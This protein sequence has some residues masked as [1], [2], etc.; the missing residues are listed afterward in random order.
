[1]KKDYSLQMMQVQKRFS[2]SSNNQ[3]IQ[4]YKPK[5][6]ATNIAAPLLYIQRVPA[7]IRRLAL[8]VCSCR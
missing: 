7:F 2:I 4:P 8:I 1:M 3:K 5:G 6:A